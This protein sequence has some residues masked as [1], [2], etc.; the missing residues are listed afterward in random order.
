MKINRTRKK[1]PDMQKHRWRMLEDE[2]WRFKR[3][4][5][6]RTIEGSQ[7]GPI[8][9]LPGTPTYKMTPEATDTRTKP[10]LDQRPAVLWKAKKTI[11]E[12][13]PTTSDFSALFTSSDLSL[14]KKVTREFL[15]E[16]C[17]D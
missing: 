10:L 16:C 14:A 11:V 9:T 5:I 13:E 2:S 8:V 7:G 12:D 1:L 17:Q 15:R 4:V 6:L 3:R